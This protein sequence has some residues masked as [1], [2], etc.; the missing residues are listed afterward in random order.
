MSS[1]IP[2]TT[3]PEV[4]N[5][6]LDVATNPGNS[7]VPTPRNLH[8]IEQVC[9][10]LLK[11]NAYI[12]KLQQT[13]TTSRMENLANLVDMEKRMKAPDNQQDHPTNANSHIRLWKHKL[14]N[15]R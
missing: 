12:N 5:Q 13:Y 10:T 2:N 8:I 15:P 9:D 7:K 3:T 6:T 1:L 4:S 14:H 11:F